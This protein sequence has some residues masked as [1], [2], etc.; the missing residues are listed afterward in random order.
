MKDLANDLEGK[1]FVVKP[2]YYMQGWKPC[3]E[4][5]VRSTQLTTK[6]VDSPWTI[7]ATV[8]ASKL[9]EPRELTNIPIAILGL[10]RL[11]NRKDPESAVSE[12]ACM[13]RNCFRG[14]AK[15]LDI[16]RAF[17]VL[18]PA[19]ALLFFCIAMA[20]SIAMGSFGKDDE[21]EVLNNTLTNL[22]NLTG[23]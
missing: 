6:G 21:E 7:S 2:N 15:C 18:G 8:E 3:Q 9:K 19:A 12:A 16:F 4:K 17:V 13:K 14:S 20:P 22:T 23:L 11:K 5:E 1:K 10:M